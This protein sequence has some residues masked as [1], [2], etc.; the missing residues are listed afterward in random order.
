M[1]ERDHMETEPH[2]DVWDRASAN[3]AVR[4]LHAKSRLAHLFCEQESR[5]EPFGF[6]PS[7]SRSFPYRIAEK[8]EEGNVK[9]WQKRA[10]HFHKFH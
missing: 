3:V 6:L 1:V 7:L 9:L 4:M 8:K 2:P 5:P 10:G